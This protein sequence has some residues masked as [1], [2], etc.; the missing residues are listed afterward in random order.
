MMRATVR[1]LV[2]V[3][4]AAAWCDAQEMGLQ[5]N[6]PNTV[7]VTGEPVVADLRVHNRTTRVFVPR[8]G[9]AD[10]LLTLTVTRK[11]DRATVEPSL[12]PVVHAADMSLPPGEVW[13]GRFEISRVF[14]M[15]RPGRYLVRLVAVH[16]GLR[17]E[18]S[19]R[20]FDVVPGFE[21]T[22]V[23]QVFPGD[24][25][26]QREL[27]LAYWVRNQMEELFLQ[28]T[29]KPETR[30]WRT[31]SLGPV[32]RTSPP[33]IDIAPDGLLTIVHRATPDVF[34]KSQVRSAEDE[35]AYQGQEKLLDPVASASKRMAPFQTMAMEYAIKKRD[36][37]GR[38]RWWWPFGGGSRK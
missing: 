29:E 26:L 35:V 38:K 11:N 37:Q 7:Y 5:V 6:T 1:I 18:S 20:A 33:V 17:Y 24:P 21:I 25:P 28:V 30:H 19:P 22:R 23:V 3:V 34:I 9:A 36:E 4:A 15:R 12:P 16:N 8:Q 10:A 13:Q 32:V 31:Y 27:R 2:G 14:P